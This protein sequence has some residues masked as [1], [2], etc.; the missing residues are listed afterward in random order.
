MVGIRINGFEYDDNSKK[1][2][3]KPTPMNLIYAW[4]SQLSGARSVDV[5]FNV[6]D[7]NFY[8]CSSILRERSEYF[9]TMLSGQWAESNVNEIEDTTDENMDENDDGDENLTDYGQKFN[10]ID[11]DEDLID[12]GDEKP[13]EK[14]DEDNDKNDEKV[15]DDCEKDDEEIDD[16]R[17]KCQIKH[18]IKISEYDPITFLAML[19]YLY[20]DQIFWTDED[21][22]SIAVK[23]FCLADRYLL[24]DLRVRAK[25]RIIC[26]L[27]ISN[28]SN[29][30]FNL[31]PKYEDLK[32]PVLNFVAKNFEEISVS[33]EFKDIMANLVNYPDYNVILSEIWAEHFKIQKENTSNN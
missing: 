21:R 33:Q 22:N 11:E 24:T 29:I 2:I 15:G 3:Y 8:A 10:K 26:E 20:T 27:N 13:N 17:L 28:V 30:M 7:Q 14:V 1:H 23:L 6:Q 19:E 5:V 16:D 32:V 31:V 25:T 12:E 9:E 4:L 18:R